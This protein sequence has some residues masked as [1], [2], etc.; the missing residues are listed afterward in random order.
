MY[1][2]ARGKDTAQ[3]KTRPN[4]NHK[5]PL[6]PSFT[7]APSFLHR[8]PKSAQPSRSVQRQSTSSHSGRHFRSFPSKTTPGVCISLQCEEQVCPMSA[9]ILKGLSP[10]R[11]FSRYSFYIFPFW[12]LFI[13]FQFTAGNLIFVPFWQFFISFY[14]YC[15]LTVKSISLSS[16]L[17]KKKKKK[18]L[19]I[20]LESEPHRSL[21]V[22]T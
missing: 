18:S 15:Y 19:D 6:Q 14:F 7:S 11:L 8:L 4:P 9:F 16:F 10:H 13:A 17:K 22:E 12:C 21:F 20:W 2:E 1:Q 3:R 5:G